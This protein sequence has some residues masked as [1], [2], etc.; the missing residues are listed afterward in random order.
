MDLEALLLLAPLLAPLGAIW[1]YE[2]LTTRLDVLTF[3]DGSDGNVTVTGTT[4]LSADM[5]Y[6]RLTVAN[7]GIL[8]L[9]GYKAFA[10]RHINLQS[11][12]IVRNNGSDAIRATAGSGGD[13][14]TLAGGGD[15]AAGANRGGGGG[16]GGG[17]VLLCTPIITANGAITA[18]GGAGADGRSGI[19]AD[20]NGVHAT[21]IDPSN[22]G[23]GGSGGGSTSHAPGRGGAVTAPVSGIIEQP[24]PFAPQFYGLNRSRDVLGIGGGGGGGSGAENS[25]QQAGGGGGGTIIRIYRILRGSGTTDVGGGAAGSSSGSSASNG[26]AGSAGKV[27]AIPLEI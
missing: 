12:S 17:V 10:R 7:G 9:N 24:S 15:G 22:G 3:G 4:T 11:G 6:D 5:F 26:K 1:T 2:Y 27:T 19:N 14:G 8:D 13:A 21:D 23:A 25:N 16:G 20:R 18:T